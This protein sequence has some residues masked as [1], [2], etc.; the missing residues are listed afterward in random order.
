MEGLPLGDHHRQGST[1]VP[2]MVTTRLPS[3]AKF[4]SRSPLYCEQ[5][6]PFDPMLL[7]T[8]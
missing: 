8:V 3:E 2:L 4:Q 7:R 6:E 5:R 1:S